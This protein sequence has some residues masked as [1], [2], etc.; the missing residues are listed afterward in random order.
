MT[1]VRMKFRIKALKRM[2]LS[3]DLHNKMTLN[4]M[5]VG[6]KTLSRMTLNSKSLSIMA[7]K[8]ITVYDVLFSDWP[9]P[10]QPSPATRV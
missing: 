1:L 5:T 10:A 3:R 8:Y 7:S 6:I 4:R 2:T 9:S